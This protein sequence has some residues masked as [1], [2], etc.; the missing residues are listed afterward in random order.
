MRRLLIITVTLCLLTL[1]ASA[2]AGSG[3]HRIPPGQ[4]RHMVAHRTVGQGPG[5][6]H[7]AV[8]RHA[9]WD[10]R[11]G[12]RYGQRFHRHKTRYVTRR[13]APARRP[14][15]VRERYI[16]RGSVQ[17]YTIRIRTTD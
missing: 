6:G 9:Q 15:V 11:H 17:E 12:H 2:W 8:R 10:H 3:N 16:D 14:V 4:A 13:C 7:K 5:W 1:S